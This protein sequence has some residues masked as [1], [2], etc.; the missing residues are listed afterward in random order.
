MGVTL[1]LKGTVYQFFPYPTL[2]LFRFLRS[3]PP[4]SNGFLF[5]LFGLWCYIGIR[6]VLLSFTHDESLTFTIVCGSTD[7]IRTANNHFLNTFLTAVSANIWGY[8]EWA[9][10]LPNVLAFGLY[11]LMGYRLLRPLPPISAILGIAILFFNPFV[12]DFFSLSRGYGLAMAF[13][14][15]AIYYLLL[16]VRRRQMRHAWLS[17]IAGFLMLYGNFS[18]LV[19]YF[20]LLLTLSITYIYY[21][22]KQWRRNS[23]PHP[24]L[25]AQ[26]LLALLASIRRDASITPLLRLLGVVAII[27]LPAVGFSVLLRQKGELYFGGNTGFFADTVQSLLLSTAYQPHTHTWLLNGWGYLAGIFYVAIILLL[28]PYWRY[29]FRSM[30]G[31]LLLQLNICIVTCLVLHQLLGLLLPIERTALYFVPLT[32]LSV[33]YGLHTLLQIVRRQTSLSAI[34]RCAALSV[35]VVLGLNWARNANLSHTLTWRYDADTYKALSTLQQDYAPRYISDANPAKVAA[36]WNLEPVLNYYRITRNFYWLDPIERDD[37][38]SATYDYYFCF[39]QDMPNLACDDRQIAMVRHF[40]LAKT[41][42][43]VE[44]RQ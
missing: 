13:E 37:M 21:Q 11:A 19:P 20:A 25:N 17:A 18:F 10:R 40:D 39:R 23:E 28:L 33:A 22:Y 43:L 1:R 42:L 9:L 41:L 4:F 8:D 27:C 29:W 2:V 16:F 30:F 7:W 15:S 14:L 31:V 38:H 24:P 35:V 44:M 12:L 5:V 32:G 34:I 6:S 26:G 3:N 36:S